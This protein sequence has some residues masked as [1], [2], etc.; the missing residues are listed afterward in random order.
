[1]ER[2]YRYTRTAAL[3]RGNKHLGAQTAV[4]YAG[5]MLMTTRDANII[6][7]ANRFGM[8]SSGQIFEILFDTDSKT[9]LD[10]ALSRLTKAKYLSVVGRHIMNPSDAGS[11]QY[12]YQL[13]TNGWDFCKRRGKYAPYRAIKHHMLEVA[14]AFVEVKRLERSGQLRV[15]DYL[16]EPDTHETIGGAKLKPDL[17]VEVE[18]KGQEGYGFPY[19]IELDRG[20]ESL[21]VIDDMLSRYF[22]AF[23]GGAEDGH[24]YLPKIVFLVPDAMRKRAIEQ[25]IARMEDVPDDLFTV[26]LAKGYAELVLLS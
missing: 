19:W 20:T 21:A 26:E 25:R 5:T 1:V 16:L 10:R 9:P 7:A 11:G 13:G 6:R 18:L 14:S 2:G 23:Q 8:L 15:V 3:T 12:C 17:F 4:R 22:R 24:D